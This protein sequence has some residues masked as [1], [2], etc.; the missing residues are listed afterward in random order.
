M[1]TTESPNAISLAE[2][3]GA[4]GALQR[5]VELHSKWRQKLPEGVRASVSGETFSGVGFAKLELPSA[6]LNSSTW[7]DSDLTEAL[8]THC[9]M[10]ASDF[11]QAVLNR[12]DLTG[13]TAEGA[14]WN[15]A[16]LLGAML[17][18][19]KLTECHLKAIH[20]DG[21]RW[22]DAQLT[23]CDLTSADLSNSAFMRQI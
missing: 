22:Q 11:R 20:A 5:I 21:S 13:V 10:D 9:E 17:G 6:N 14:R 15:E 23:R 4:A 19:V 8:L 18:E 7:I 3:T 1:L 12:A 16:W 2:R